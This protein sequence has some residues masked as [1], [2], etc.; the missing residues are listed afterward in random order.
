MLLLNPARA[1]R[2]DTLLMKL[3]PGARGPWG[4]C[5]LVGLVG[6]RG[7]RARPRALGPGPFAVGAIRSGLILKLVRERLKLD[8]LEKL[9]AA[10]VD[11]RPVSSRLS[12]ASAGPWP[13]SSD[14]RAKVEREA[15]K[16]FFGRV[17]ISLSLLF[18]YASKAGGLKAGRGLSGGGGGTGESGV[19]GVPGTRGEGGTE[20]A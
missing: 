11:G 14:V 1:I 12:I 5:G 10:S 15:S 2:L 16:L 8:R 4:G 17:E 3:F 7:E 6:D 9:L 13:E 20:P 18:A 19:D